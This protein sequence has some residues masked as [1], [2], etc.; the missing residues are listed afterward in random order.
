MRYSVEFASI[1]DYRG[2]DSLKVKREKSGYGKFD[3]Y[4]G[5]RIDQNCTNRS[6]VGV[7]LVP[8]AE[9]R[10]HYFDDGRWLDNGLVF[11]VAATSV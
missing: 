3:N 11:A 9:R 6:P 5:T 1:G 4:F 10:V 7:E 8:W 2:R